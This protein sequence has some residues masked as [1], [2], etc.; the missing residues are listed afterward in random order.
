MLSFKLENK[1]T[2][3]NINWPKYIDLHH[4]DKELAKKQIVSIVNAMLAMANICTLTYAYVTD[5]E[6]DKAV[7]YETDAGEWIAT[8]KLVFDTS[9]YDC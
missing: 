6:G 3:H 7:V 5:I 8:Y 2:G 1:N 4:N 9:A